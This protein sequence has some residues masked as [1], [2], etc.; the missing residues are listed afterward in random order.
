MSKLA[1]VMLIVVWL[2]IKRA[3]RVLLIRLH[4][5]HHSVNII[6]ISLELVVVMVGMVLVLTRHQIRM[7]PSLIVR[8]HLISVVSLHCWLVHVASH[9]L[10][11]IVVM[12]IRESLRPCTCSFFFN[13]YIITPFSFSLLLLTAFLLFI[14]DVVSLI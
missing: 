3:T 10:L 11:L 7:I 6:V 4:W 8:R 9:L 1:R 12:L 13:I 14:I 2:L 5:V